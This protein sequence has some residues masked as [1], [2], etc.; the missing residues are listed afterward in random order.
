MSEQQ[1]KIFILA[2]HPVVGELIAYRLRLHDLQP[3]LLDSEQELNDALGEYLPQTFMIDLDMANCDGIQLVEKLAS[4]EVTS[5]VPILCMSAEGDL[6]RAEQ[7]FRAG[8]RDFLVIPFDPIVLEEKVTRL[9][10]QFEERQ[11]QDEEQKA[12]AV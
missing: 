6:D 11:T 3:I 12:A 8:G 2:S 7:A 10:E 1:Y 9:L 5:R 4:D